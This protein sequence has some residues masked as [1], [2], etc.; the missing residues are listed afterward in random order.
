MPAEI[1]TEVLRST[2]LSFDCWPWSL[3]HFGQFPVNHRSRSFFSAPR[4]RVQPAD[5]ASIEGHYQVLEGLRR[6]GRAAINTHSAMGVTAAIKLLMTGIRSSHFF[7]AAR[8]FASAAESLTA[9]AFASSR[10]AC[11][12]FL[13]L[14]SRDRPWAAAAC[15]ASAA[16]QRAWAF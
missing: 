13:C 16:F 9:P 15:F 14:R 11:D 4:N 1:V 2:N 6:I 3:G 8:A 7:K 5:S 12:C 10:L